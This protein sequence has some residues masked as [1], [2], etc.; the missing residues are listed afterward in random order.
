M[1]PGR[2]LDE[3]A[4]VLEVDYDL[5]RI[6]LLHPSVK[7]C[8]KHNG[9]LMTVISGFGCTKLHLNGLSFGGVTADVVSD[10][11]SVANRRTAHTP[12]R[13]HLFFHRNFDGVIR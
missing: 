13:T 5:A 11:K 1:L 2:L 8:S 7:N 12:P 6:L 4:I 3:T 10:P 9:Y